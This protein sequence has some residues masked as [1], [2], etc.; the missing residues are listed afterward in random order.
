MDLAHIKRIL[1]IRTDKIGDVLLSLPAVIAVREAFPDA[2]IAMMISPEAKDILAGNEYLNEVIIYDKKIKHKNALNTLGFISQ[3]RKKRF[4]IAII[5]HSTTRVNLIAFLSGI[6][7][8]I[9]YARGKMDLLLSEKLGYTKRFGEKHEAEYCL[10][11]LRYI[12]I[13]AKL[14][15]PK[16]NIAEKD[17]E[18]IKAMLEGCGV[19]EDY[20][21]VIIHP[22]SS[23]VSRRWPVENFSKTADILV[24]DMGLHIVLISSQDPEQMRIAGEVRSLM[25]N[26]AIDL[27]GKTSVGELA[28][29]C[30][31]AKLLI[32]N[33]SGPAHIASSV[34]TPVISIFSGKDKGLGP[35]RWKCLGSNSVYIH[36]DAG[37]AQCLLENC[38]KGFLCL[39][40]ITPEEV[41]EKAKLLMKK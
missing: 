9:G 19:K 1:I 33:I 29:L 16:L 27:C 21:I 22:G 36:K 3:I 8:R 31:R 24:K 34:G 15:L 23:H 13:D 28:A 10:D 40:S 37:C 12:G 5:L 30:K 11:V 25:K 7:A 39:R 2:Y 18:K 41:A 20:K 32:S 4:D 26:E 14:S 6:P 17:R 38:E 35:V